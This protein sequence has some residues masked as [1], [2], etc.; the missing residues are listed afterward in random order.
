MNK[1]L[2]MISFAKATKTAIPTSLKL[3]RSIVFFAKATKT[4]GGG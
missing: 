1:Q 3:R 2:S 4:D